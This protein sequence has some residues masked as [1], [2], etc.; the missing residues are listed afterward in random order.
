MDYLGIN[1]T[2]YIQVPDR[3]TENYKGCCEKLKGG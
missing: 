1:L 3:D 2:Q